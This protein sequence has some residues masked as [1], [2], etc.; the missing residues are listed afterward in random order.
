MIGCR[1][2]LEHVIERVRKDAIDADATDAANILLYI[3]IYKYLDTIDVHSIIY[4]RRSINHINRYFE[5]TKITQ[6]FSLQIFDY[7]RGVCT[8]TLLAPQKTAATFHL[9]DLKARF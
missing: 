3:L 8:L 5:R 7:H 1:T 2:N 9:N 6:G 4:T